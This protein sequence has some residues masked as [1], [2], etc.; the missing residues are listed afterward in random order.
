MAHYRYIVFLFLCVTACATAPHGPDPAASHLSPDID[1]TLS[2]CASGQ[3]PCGSETPF[4][5]LMEKTRTPSDNGPDHYINL[6]EQGDDALVAR[7]HLI[8]SARHAIELQTFIWGSDDVSDLFFQELLLA[9]RRGVRVRVLVDQLTGNRQG[10]WLKYGAVAHKNLQIKLYNPTFYKGKNTALDLMAAFLFY[11]RTFNQ[12]MHN[13]VLI[14]DGAVGITGGRNIERKYFDL[15]PEFTFKDRDVLVIGPVVADMRHSFLEYWRDKRSVPLCRLNDIASRRVRP[16]PRVFAP[17]APM[18]ATLSRR[19]S[20]NRYIQQTFIDTATPISGPVWFFADRPGKKPRRGKTRII[21]CATGLKQI[22]L[23]ADHSLV[24]QTPYLLLSRK[25]LRGFKHLR[26]KTPAIDIIVST[27]SLV[28][29]DSL[30]VY[31]VAFKQK[32]K[33]VKK[34]KF[35]IFELKAMPADVRK[36][37]RGYDQLAAAFR[38][39]VK[40]TEQSRSDGRIHPQVSIHGK[41]FVVDDTVAWI[42]SHNFDPRSEYYNT[43]AALAIW[44]HTVAIQVKNNILRDAAPQNSY[45]IARQPQ[46]PVISHLSGLI[47]SLS[48]A[49]PFL[50][51]WPFRYTTSYELRAGK[52]PVPRDDPRFL[53]HYRNVE[54]FPGI[55]ISIR[56]MEARLLTAM[57]GFVWPIL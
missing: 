9:A 30:S 1:Q 22:L 37:V 3:Y 19:A 50:D 51:I 23:D 34:L 21:S 52:T 53:D 26:K 15:D 35:K 45:F 12:R 56:A 20:D 5:R 44:D 49:L 27:N 54:A 38:R 31:A 11:Y 47:G 14:V 40:N 42:G 43:E 10:K 6:L 41:S 36:M 29:S 18:L 48:R 16:V 33:M 55:N 13:K 7:L 46:V 17:L 28:T 24:I 57:G 25:A 8:R 39:R 32:K 4:S 2:G